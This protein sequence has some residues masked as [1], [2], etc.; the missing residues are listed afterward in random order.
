M[1][2]EDG[3]RIGAGLEQ[4]MERHPATRPL[5]ATALLLA[6]FLLAVPAAR[7]GELAD[8]SFG[9]TSQ[10]PGSA[11]GLDLAVVFHTA[12]N[13]DAKS[14]PVRGVVIEG[15]RGLRF[16]SAA[17][18]LCSASDAEFRALGTLA[19]PAESEVGF[20]SYTAMTGF[21]A[22]VDP[23][24]G[25]NHVFNAEGQLVEVITFPGTTISPGF[26]RLTVEGSTITAHPPETPGGPPDMQTATRSVAFSIPVRGAFITTPPRCPRKRRWVARGHFTFADGSRETVT[27][28]TPCDRRA[29]RR[30]RR[31]G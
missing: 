25:D 3:R 11:T 13:P 17:A 28:T 12:G 29:A 8:L 10:A 15:P 24:V 20:G 23:F 9:L 5:L 1:R 14:S 31:R 6:V 22:P 16:D 2:L 30:S 18:P 7:A 4:P 26:D 19:C 27:A 21:G